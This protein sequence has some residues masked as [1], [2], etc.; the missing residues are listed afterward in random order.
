MTTVFNPTNGSNSFGNVGSLYSPSLSGDG[1]YV[2]FWSTSSDITVG[3][4]DFRTGNSNGTAQV[5]RLRSLLKSLDQVSVANDGITQGN[6]N[7][8]VL[9]IGNNNNDDWA[10]AL[11]P[12]GRFVRVQ[13]SAT[14]LVNGV[15]TSGT[16]VFL[17]DL[18]THT[19]QLVS[20]AAN[21]SGDSIRPAISPDG[22]TITFVSDAGNLPGA[23][24]GEQA[25]AVVLDPVTLV[26]GR[27]SCCRPAS[28]ASTTAS[29]RSAT[30]SVPAA[31]ALPS[32]GAALGFNPDQGGAVH[33]L[34]GTIAFAAA[35]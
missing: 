26:Q 24:G 32:G 28:P 10:P 19:I 30:P 13:S 4:T 3:G 14:N 33:N 8:A 2:S 21:G 16:N 5:L 20:A 35:R 25:Y 27:P 9:N 18:Q 11:S 31:S 15:S 22:H 7:S 34:D 23:T 6:A 1:R 12:D 17:Y 29:T